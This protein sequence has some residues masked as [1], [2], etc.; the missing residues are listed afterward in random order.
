MKPSGARTRPLGNRLELHS[1]VV[2][3]GLRFS[4]KSS[5]DRGGFEPAIFGGTIH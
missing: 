2:E 4:C 3:R 1:S 5:G